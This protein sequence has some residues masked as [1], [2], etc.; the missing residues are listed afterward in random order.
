MPR[1]PFHRLFLAVRPPAT[2]IPEI[3][4]L[5]DSFGQTRGL[6]ADGHLHLTTWLFEDSQDFPAEAAER[7]RAVVAALELLRFRIVLERMIGS[8]GRVVL[9]PYAPLPGFVALQSTLDQAL[10][11]AG[12]RPHPGWRFR[13]HMTLLHGRQEID[14]SIA[15]ISW[16]VD[17][18]VLLDS[19][20]GERRHDVIARWPLT[21]TD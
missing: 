3:G 6:V 8:G 11:G 19:V 17:N 16:D 10:S 18:L 21:T 5:R 1:E 13:P 12:L 2:V 15:P 14:Q 7:A 20:V 9:V 4:G